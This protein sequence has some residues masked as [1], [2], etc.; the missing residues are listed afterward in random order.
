MI[1]DDQPLPDWLARLEAQIEREDAE[2]AAT[3]EARSRPEI[4]TYEGFASGR[5]ETQTADDGSDTVDQA[6][7]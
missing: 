3:P 1:S 4:E 2:D 7:H 6:S 5:V